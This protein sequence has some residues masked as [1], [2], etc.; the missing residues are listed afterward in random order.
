MNGTM[1]WGSFSGLAWLGVACAV[2]EHPTLDLIW[3]GPGVNG[4]NYLGSWCLVGLGEST[5]SFKQGQPKTRGS[6]RNSSQE[7]K[8]H[9]RHRSFHDLP[10]ARSNI[11]W[12]H[13]ALEVLVELGFKRAQTPYSEP[14]L[15][16]GIGRKKG[17][18]LWV[19]F[20][21]LAW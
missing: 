19:S 13:F 15:C 10:H 21:G 7:R 20:S 17:T 9:P 12:C 5:A 16:R 14:C 2:K 11:G 18:M 6:C 1:L 4:S 8:I 3:G